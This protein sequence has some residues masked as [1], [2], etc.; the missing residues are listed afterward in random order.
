MPVLVRLP[1]GLRTAVVGFVKTASFEDD[2]S[3]AA[4][5]TYQTR[6]AAA[7]AI[8]QG[9]RRKRLPLLKAMVT[10][11]AGVLVGGHGNTRSS[12]SWNVDFR[13]SEVWAFHSSFALHSLTTP[14]RPRL[15]VI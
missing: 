15:L 4:K 5:E 6:L 13:G 14:E 1:L 3:A 8:G 12:L 9:R 10:R 11:S 2:G 7:G